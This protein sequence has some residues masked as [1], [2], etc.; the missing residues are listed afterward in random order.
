MVSCCSLQGASVYESVF[1]FCDTLMNP[2]AGAIPGLLA[3]L[4]LHL[5]LLQLL[6]HKKAE[7]GAGL[8]RLLFGQ[9]SA[10]MRLRWSTL[11]QQILSLQFAAVDNF[12]PASK[13]S[14]FS[15][16]KVVTGFCAAY[17]GLVLLLCL[18]LQGSSSKPR[19]NPKGMAC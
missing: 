4:Q 7:P 1:A 11:S 10:F 9:Q 17:K 14:I 8:S 5:R 19:V 13:P 3:V 15:G 2:G 18:V 12:Q 6:E 16:H